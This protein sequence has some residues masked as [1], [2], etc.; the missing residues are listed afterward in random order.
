MPNIASNALEYPLLQRIEVD[1][2]SKKGAAG[3]KLGGLLLSK[4]H[5]TTEAKARA[6]ET[7]GR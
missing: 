1:L 7:W 3:K 5:Q 4:W 2:V 6:T